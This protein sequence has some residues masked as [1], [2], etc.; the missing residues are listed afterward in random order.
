MLILVG[1]LLLSEP[2]LI[3]KQQD[4]RSIMGWFFRQKMR[5]VV[6]ISAK[7]TILIFLGLQLFITPDRFLTPYKHYVFGSSLIILG[8]FEL[9]QRIRVTQIREKE[10]CMYL[11]ILQMGEY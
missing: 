10:F 4:Q 1:I 6:A 3:D 7:A 11:E 9:V 5:A 8:V 2:L